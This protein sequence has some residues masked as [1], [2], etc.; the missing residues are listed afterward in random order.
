ME[1]CG[2]KKRH[3][4]HEDERRNGDL[5]PTVILEHV[6]VVFFARAPKGISLKEIKPQKRSLIVQN[7]PCF[8]SNPQVA[9]NGV[10]GTPDMSP[11][12]PISVHKSP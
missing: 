6:F 10:P 4:C 11:A 9:G 1:K 2:R 8:P 7:R 5:W 12:S 3:D